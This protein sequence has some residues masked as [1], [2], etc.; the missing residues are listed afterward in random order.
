[1]RENEMPLVM[2]SVLAED[3]GALTFQ[4]G[5]SHLLNDE[6]TDEERE[7]VNGMIDQLL[8]LLEPIFM[9]VADE[10][11]EDDEEP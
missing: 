8:D 2:L 3:D 1:M 10:A 9:R 6:M 5:F 4:S 7:R 11:F